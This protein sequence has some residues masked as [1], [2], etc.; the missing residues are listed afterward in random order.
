MKKHK[1]LLVFLPIVIPFI[2]GFIYSLLKSLGFW[3]PIGSVTFHHWKK[4]IASPTTYITLGY[5]AYIAFFSTLISFVIALTLL[6]HKP[7]QANILVLLPLILPPVSVGF[8]F[9]QLLSGHGFFA[10]LFFKFPIIKGWFTADLSAQSPHGLAIIM[11]LTFMTIPVFYA[12]LIKIFQEEKIGDQIQLSRELGASRQL[13]IWK[14]AIPPLIHKSK[15]LMLL[16][17]VFA[18]SSYEIPLLLGSQNPK[19]V[20]VYIIDKIQKFDLTT[21][22]EG[23]GLMVIYIFLIIL[24]GRWL[25]QILK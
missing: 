24:L 21:I 10:R 19:M 25:F 9:L 15:F 14:I 1:R 20:T 8:I 13:S 6:F 23:H 12:F 4:I 17:F 11:A 5:S 2:V 7:F 22:P 18:L 3:D 16:Y